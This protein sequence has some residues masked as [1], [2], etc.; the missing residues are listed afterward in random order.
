AELE[1]MQ[2]YGSAYVQLDTTGMRAVPYSVFDNLLGIR[3]DWSRFSIETD[4]VYHDNGVDKFKFDFYK[5]TGSGPF[6]III[7]IHGGGFIMGDKGAGN[8]PDFN[9]YFASRGFA[10]FDVQYGLYDAAELLPYMGNVGPFLAALAPLMTPNYNKSYTIEEM[11]LNLGRFTKY[12]DANNASFNV[13]LSRVFI[14]G[15]SAGGCLASIITTCYENPLFAGNFSSNFTIKGGAWI[16]PI[17]NLEALKSPFFDVLLQGSLP[18]DQQYEK[19]SASF[20]IKNSTEVP[21]ILLVH[22]DKDNWVNYWVQSVAFNA[23]ASSLGK[24]CTLV[25]IPGMGHAFDLLFHSLGG[26]LSTYYIERFF[27]LNL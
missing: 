5:P 6:P 3:I 13:D 18:L 11:V 4:L 2:D 14:V 17:T 26:Q 16:Y 10:V 24:K 25:T 9:K 23:L 27:Q 21:P 1:F 15:R 8:M 12:L 19:Y 7:A 22:G 20:L